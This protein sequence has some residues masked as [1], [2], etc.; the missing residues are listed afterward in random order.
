MAPTKLESQS[1][2]RKALAMFNQTGL[3]LIEDL[4][5]QPQCHEL[6]SAINSYR[7]KYNLPLIFRPRASRSLKYM[8]IDGDRVHAFLPQLRE[9]YTSVNNLLNKMCPLQL[10]PLSNRAA[11]INVNIIPPGGEY[12]WHY[13]RNAVTAV[14]FLN[15]VPGGATE[16][17]PNYRIYLGRRQHTSLQ[18]V[19]DRLLCSHVLRTL[20]GKSVCARPRPGFLLIMRGDRCLHSVRTVEGTEDRVSVVMAFDT[21]SGVRPSQRDLDSYLYTDR[22]CVSCDPNYHK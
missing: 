6:L 16:M 22:A 9:L 21:L 4:L 2:M 13:D 10:V 20:F 15:E 3:E 7:H 1:E 11:R 8:V 17:Y 5:P 14:L 19:L 18:R 12:R